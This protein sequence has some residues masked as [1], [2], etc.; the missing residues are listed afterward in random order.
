VGNNVGI[1]A[2]AWVDRDASVVATASSMGTLGVVV[3]V[4][5]EHEVKINSNA[6]NIKKYLMR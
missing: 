2:G 3:L 4:G 5:M 6:M 1:G